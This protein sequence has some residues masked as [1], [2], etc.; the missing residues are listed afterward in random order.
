MRL[1]LPSTESPFGVAA[2][3]AVARV[4]GWPRLLSDHLARAPCIPAGFASWR[5]GKRGAL[6]VSTFLAPGSTFSP[7]CFGLATCQTGPPGWGWGLSAVQVMFSHGCHDG[8]SHYTFQ[9]HVARQS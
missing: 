5:N 8:L 4:A 6:S 2:G 9:F 7:A 3:R 1:Y